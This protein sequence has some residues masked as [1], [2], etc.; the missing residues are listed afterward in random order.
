MG[1]AE[2]ALW[3]A[4]QTQDWTEPEL[5]ILQ[6]QWQAPDF[7]QDL[8]ET[9][10]CNRAIILASL[11]RDSQQT[12]DPPLPTGRIT[13]QLFSS[14]TAAWGELQAGVRA[15]RY[16]KYGVYEDE[17]EMLLYYR[18]KELEFRSAVA[19]PTWAAMRGLPGITN[20]GALRRSLSSS[21][22]IPVSTGPKGP[23][24]YGQGFGLLR[25]AA[26]AETLRRLA[27]TALALQRFRLF[28]GN[29]PEALD[30]L[31]PALLP[32]RPID[33]MDGKP[34]RYRPTDGNHF[35]LYSVGL[36]CIDDGGWMT[37]TNLPPGS[38]G[39][40]PPSPAQLDAYG[41]ATS[42]LSKW[43]FCLNPAFIFPL[44]RTMAPRS[45]S[46]AS[47]CAVCHDPGSLGWWML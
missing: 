21:L 28:R 25:R 35:V 38:F 16:R 6:A 30:E 19:A 40:G 22:R 43:P 9:A 36:D 42:G 20:D 10:A 46:S 34:L 33:F 8:P 3:E 44:A 12:D 14:P 37:R 15:S 41:C 4:L 18:D 23:G 31:V 47:N 24:F 11:R 27:V 5:A 7:F 1:T 13:S 39:S 17:Q 32:Q 29:Y 45:K 2:R 26:E